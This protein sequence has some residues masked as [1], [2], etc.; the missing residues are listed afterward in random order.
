VYVPIGLDSGVG[1]MTLPVSYPGLF[2]DICFTLLQALTEAIKADG[3]NRYSTRLG[4]GF[5]VPWKRQGLIDW[6]AMVR[7]HRNETGP[8]IGFQCH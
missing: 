3:I 4:W 2:S 7:S 8:S 6:A 1:Y 5:R